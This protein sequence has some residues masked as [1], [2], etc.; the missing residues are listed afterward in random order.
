MVLQHAG[1]NCK[2]VSSKINNLQT[3]GFL[4]GWVKTHSLFTMVLLEKSNADVHD[5]VY[6][7]IQVNTQKAAL[8]HTT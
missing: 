4:R 1:A 3:G 7:N 6:D 2:A 8:V 5:Y